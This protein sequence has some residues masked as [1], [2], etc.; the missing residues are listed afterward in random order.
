M[1]IM[2]RTLILHICPMY[3]LYMSPQHIETGPIHVSLDKISSRSLIW[4]RDSILQAGPVSK[5]ETYSLDNNPK[6]F[7]H[8]PLGCSLIS[9][10]DQLFGGV[11]YHLAC[12]VV[13]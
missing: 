13:R 2:A 6:P 4:L 12:L 5:F 3:P 7:H 10:F 9:M 11:Q 8:L 1:I